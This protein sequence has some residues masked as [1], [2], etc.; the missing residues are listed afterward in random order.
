MNERAQIVLT[1]DRPTGRLHLGHYVGSL[2]Q[3]VKLQNLHNQFVMIADTQALTDHSEKPDLVRDN[4]LEVALD[5][6]SVGVDP[7]KTTFLIQ[8]TI[9]ALPELALYFLNLVTLARLER[10]P[11]VKEEVRLKGYGMNVPAGFFMYPVSQAADILAFK[12]TLVPVGDDQLPMIEQANEIGHKFNSIYGEIFPKVQ[13][14][15][16]ESARLPGIDGKV[17]MGKSL[18]NAI[19]LSDSEEVVKEKVM[20]MYTD[21]DHIHVSDSGKVEGNMVFTYLDVFDSKKDELSDLKNSY[22]K[23]GLGDVEIKRRLAVILNTF[24]D[25]IREER[26]RLEK[27]KNTIFEILKEGS[28]KANLIA[29]AT[30]NEAKRAMKIN[31]F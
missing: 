27:D 9:R 7:A 22:T 20:Q 24:L 28:A 18:G 16:T 8:S 4:V 10:N 15:V 21:P 23:G 6:M 11:T 30:L 31:Y 13:P 3:R 17:K 26:A 1:G 25:P 29:D 5:N 19:Y 14:L 2:K 12:S